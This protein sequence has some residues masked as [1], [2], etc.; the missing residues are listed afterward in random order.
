MDIALKEWASVVR[1]LE[2]G[3]QIVI[4]RKGGIS[5]V[6]GRFEVTHEEFLLYPT[7]EHQIE[8]H[9]QPEWRKLIRESEARHIE[10]KVRFSS[11]ARVEQI[12]RV[13][14][15]EELDRLGL[16]HIFAPSY[17]DMRFA[18][19]PELPLYVLVLRVLLLPEPVVI[20]ETPTY[21]GCRSWVTLKE[22]IP[23]QAAHPV[24]T[25]EEFRRRL[26]HIPSN[27]A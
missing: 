21:A 7:Y 14:S 23:I 15:P 24:L 8:R 10:G 13:G 11:W 20:D 25:D 6:E 1:A 3:V 19:K 12:H 18:Y 22:D 16:E 17:L 26:A 4:L 27:G 2:E 9:L 5:E